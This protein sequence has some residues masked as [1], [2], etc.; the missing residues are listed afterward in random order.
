MTESR[1]YSVLAVDG[2]GTRCR[3]AFARGLEIVTV[4]TGA[5]NVSTDFDG[6]V[7]EILRALD[8]VTAETD[9]SI[10]ALGRVPAFVGLAGVTGPEMAERLRAALPFLHVDI[11]DD[12]PAAL[13]GALGAEDGVIAHCGTGSFLAA[14]S[15]GE[16]RF[17]GG[18]GPVLGDEASAQWIGR[19]ALGLTL[20][21]VD[22]RFDETGLSAHFLSE[23]GD[24]AGIVRFA[25][26][27]TPPELGAL[28][29]IVTD[30]AAS[31]DALAVRVM[32]DG[33]NDLVRAIPDIGWQPGQRICL[34]GGIGPQFAR[35]LPKTQQ[36]HITDPVGEPLDGALA[37]AR[38]LA[39]ETVHERD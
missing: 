35:Y 24:A 33:A 12:R 6:A 23:F 2:G 10:H 19:R 30:R 8:M 27:A 38:D 29:P 9:Q 26:G 1:S 5:A 13:R 32:Q 11:R 3:V 34:T 4:E 14:Q 31:G 21:A 20:Q 16:M 37:L 36:A 25:G 15:R 39:E 17:A 7:S 18:W 22:G 28:A